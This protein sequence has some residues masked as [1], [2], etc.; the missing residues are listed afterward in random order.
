MVDAPPPRLTAGDSWG[1]TA[2]Q[3]FAAYPPP[4][5]A[6]SY[7]FRPE[8]GGEILTA[9]ATWGDTYSVSL[10]AAQTAPLA[11]GRYLWAAVVENDATGARITLGRGAIEVEADPMASTQDTRSSAARILAA[12]EDLIAGRVNKDAESYSIEGRSLTRTPIDGL[13]RLEGIFRARVA[14]ERRRA[15]GQSPFE[16]RRVSR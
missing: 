1:W 4:D 3:A 15:A 12:I 5:F 13:I 11:P 9:V 7:S 6:L 8:A 14:A 16:I 2:P 10:P